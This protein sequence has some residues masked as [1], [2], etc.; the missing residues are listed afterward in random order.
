MVYIPC[1]VKCPQD[2]ELVHRV[3]NVCLWWGIHEVELQQVIDSQ[4]FQQ[5]HDVS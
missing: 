1:V 2:P 5:Q 4:R 3:E